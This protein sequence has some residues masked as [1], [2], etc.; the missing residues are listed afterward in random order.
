[1]KYRDQFKQA[2]KNGET[3]VISSIFKKEWSKN[4]EIVGKLISMTEITD[5]KFDK[6]YYSYLFATDEGNIKAALGAGVDQEVRPFMRVGETYLV[7][8]KGKIDTGKGS[9][10][11]VFEVIRRKPKTE[12]DLEDVGQ[13]ELPLEE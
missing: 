8:F 5:A 2:E 3:E 4:E 12:P 9:P 13:S 11:K 7:R 10:M 6:A 1:M